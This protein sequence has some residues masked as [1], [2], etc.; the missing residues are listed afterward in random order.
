VGAQSRRRRG[1][2]AGA[3]HI[4]V[5]DN[6]QACVRLRARGQIRHKTLGATQF[7]YSGY[8]ARDA[9]GPV[10]VVAIYYS[11]AGGG[12]VGA[13]HTTLSGAHYYT[14]IRKFGLGDT[15]HKF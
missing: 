4:I 10:R 14:R 9:E 12:G 8:G 7:L 5:P 1:A 3:R 15:Q 13:G 6:I 11:G 2:L